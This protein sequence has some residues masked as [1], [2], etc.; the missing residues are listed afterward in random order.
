MW[1]ISVLKDTKYL[2]WRKLKH[3]YINIAK[4][5]KLY[6]FS[7]ENSLHSVTFLL[8]THCVVDNTLLLIRMTNPAAK[9]MI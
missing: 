4:K 2:I 9:E 1:V 3:L 8:K 5:Y 6:N 7:L